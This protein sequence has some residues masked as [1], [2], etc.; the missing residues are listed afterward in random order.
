MKF[1][2]LALMAAFLFAS[3]PAFAA[4]VDM[5]PADL[6]DIYGSFGA[7]TATI[8]WTAAD[9]TNKQQFTGTGREIILVK[10]TGVAAKTVTVTSAADDLG[11]TKDITAYS[12]AAGAT[13]IIGPVPLRGFAQ[14]S[15]KIYFEG[16]HA[17][18]SFAVV[19]L[20]K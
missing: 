19:R 5:T 14:T 2:L 12:V 16:E 4:R 9:A 13:A 20:R 7:G 10:N 8:T 3:V 6:N 17:D 1:K 18:I 11:R 15:N